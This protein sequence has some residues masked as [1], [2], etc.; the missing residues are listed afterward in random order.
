MLPFDLPSTDGDSFPPKWDGRNFVWGDQKCPVL[1]YSENSSGWADD[2]TALHEE[3]AGNR[4]PI[5]LASRY[6]ALLQVKKYLP[7]QKAVIA[8]IGCSSGFFIQD[9]L[10]N[11]PQAVIIGADVVKEPLYRLAGNLP[12]VPLFRFDLLRCPL[13]DQSVD[14][15]VM[16]N[17]LEHIEDDRTALKK[18]FNLLKP[19]GVLIIE[20]PAFPALYDA[21]D[22]QLHHFRRY[23][24]GRLYGMLAQAGFKV[25]RKSYLGFLLFPAF[26]AVKLFK[27]QFS[28]EKNDM[29]VRQRINKTA[30]NVLVKWALEIESKFLSNFSLP[31]GIR[32]LMTAQR[33]GRS[34]A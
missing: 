27:K 16:L 19:G 15:L 18:A 31:F 26:A 29:V 12:G 5:D 23:S 21:Y 1:E 22:A 8:E 20:V 33:P 13:P 10:K 11:F 4:H 3:T 6:D 24:S 9:L 2:L 25:Q 30:G 34:K 7:S 28:V 32:V 14:V 17:V